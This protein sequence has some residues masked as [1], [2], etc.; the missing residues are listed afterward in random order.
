M[1]VEVFNDYQSMCGEAAIFISK[2]IIKK[3]D[4]VLGLPT[5]R[6]P[7][8]M[9]EKLV[10][11]YEEGLLDYA[12]I[13]TFNLDEYYPISPDHPNSF[14]RYMHKRF[15]D[16]VNVPDEKVHIL[17]G[18]TNKPKEECREYEES[19]DEYGGLDLTVLGIGENGH[20]AYNEPNSAPDSQTRL[21]ELGEGTVT[22]ELSGKINQAL[23]MGIRTIMR[24]NQILLLASGV[25]KSEPIAKSIQGPVTTDHPASLL[26]LH[27]SVTFYLD[28]DAAAK[29]N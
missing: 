13:A 25:R 21:V 2:Q 16:R 9:Y 18:S 22:S 4:L 8:A 14:F 26:Q 11:F 6:T 17:D 19:I 29:L 3:P 12:E 7:E 23:T 15:F 28:T 1:K 24:S 27:P 5:G 20:I 10:S